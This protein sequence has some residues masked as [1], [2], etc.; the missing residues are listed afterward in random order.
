[1]HSL[2]ETTDG[3]F[4]LFSKENL[5][6]YYPSLCVLDLW[7]VEGAWETGYLREDSPTTRYIFLDVRHTSVD[8]VYKRFISP[9]HIN[10]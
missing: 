3:E 2:E 1:M 8:T 4:H 5:Y 10:E 7:H 6:I 9:S